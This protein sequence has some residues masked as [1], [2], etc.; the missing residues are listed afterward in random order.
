MNR[1]M[2]AA[3]LLDRLPFALAA[4]CIIGLGAGFMLLEKARYPGFTDN[5]TIAYFAGLSFFV[6]GVWLVYDYLRQAA[7]YRQIGQALER[8][9]ELEAGAIVRSPATREQRVAAA[10]LKE[11]HRAYVNELGAYR[12]KQELHHHFALQ[13]VH[14]MKTPVSVVD[15]LAQEALR[16]MPAENAVFRRFA[17]SVKEEAEKMAEGLELML[18]TARLEKFDLDLHLEQTPL[19][20]V[21]RGV[22]NK[23]K[24]LFIRHSIFPSVEGEAWAVTD[25]KWL[26]FVLT[27]L[28]TNAVKY[29]K[30]KPGAKK[31]VFRLRSDARDGSKLS[32]TD[33]GIGIASHDLPRIFHPFF[34]GENGRASGDSTGMGLYLAKQ[35]CDRLGHG[36]GAVSDPGRGTTITV[37]FEADGIHLLGGR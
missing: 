12:R 37:S 5:G 3:Y 22:I 9:G 33:E 17:G 30:V 29:S 21:V 34:T 8:S 20:D 14:H 26:S 23:H 32:V 31:L 28:V 1:R 10:L 18:H 35:V 25:G 27:Q 19:H 4:V 16:Q 7:Y 13:W 2:L 6:I 36:I 15:M 24:R 11:Q